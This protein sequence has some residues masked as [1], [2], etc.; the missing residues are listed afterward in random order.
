MLVSEDDLTILASARFSASL[1]GRLTQNCGAADVVGQNRASIFLYADARSIR[2][3]FCIYPI[4]YGVFAPPTLFYDI[5]RG[6]SVA[7]W[8]KAHDSK[9]CGPARVSEVRILS[10]PPEEFIDFL[11]LAEKLVDFLGSGRF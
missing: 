3:F 2:S 6:G 5:I 4:Y 10:L 11:F 7:E 9:S 1:H 8:L